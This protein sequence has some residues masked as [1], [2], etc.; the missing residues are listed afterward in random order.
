MQKTLMKTRSP[1]PD[2]SGILLCRPDSH[3]EAQKI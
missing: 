2:E 3:R 1:S